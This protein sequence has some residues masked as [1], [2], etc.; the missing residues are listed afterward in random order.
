MH[1]RIGVN[2]LLQI[3]G[4]IAAATLVLYFFV[5]EFRYLLVVMGICGCGLAFARYLMEWVLA[6][7][8]GTEDMRRISDSIRQ[9]SDGEMDEPTGG[10]GAPIG[11]RH[12][13]NLMLPAPR[14]RHPSSDSP[15]LLLPPPPRFPDDPVQRN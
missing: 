8:D 1:S 13:S 6:K 10:C 15:P 11:L 2:R 5:G 4:A 12:S 3:A 7:D 14:Y 9:G